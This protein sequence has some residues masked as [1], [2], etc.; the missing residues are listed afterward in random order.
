MKPFDLEAAKAGAP[1][2]TRDGRPAKF[3][4]HVAEAHPSQR[5]LLLIDGVVHTKFEN[6]KHANRPAHVSPNDLLMAPVKRTVWV[7]LYKYHAALWHDTEKAADDC[8]RNNRL[9]GRAWPIEIEE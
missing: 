5:L 8:A 6:G 9:G 1:I 2:V 7:N 3:I 4:A